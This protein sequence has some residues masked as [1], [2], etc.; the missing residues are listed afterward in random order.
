MRGRNWGQ[1]Q[2][3]PFFPMRWG[4]KGEE[5][6]FRL[7]ATWGNGRGAVRLRALKQGGWRLVAVRDRGIEGRKSDTDMRAWRL[8]YQAGW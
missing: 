4:R 5:G 3:V 2:L 1:R 6:G 7:V 8:L